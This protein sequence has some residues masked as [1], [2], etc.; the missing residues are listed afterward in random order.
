MTLKFMQNPN[1]LD[2]N[3]DDRRPGIG[4]RTS[5]RRRIEQDDVDETDRPI[6][7]DKNSYR[8]VLVPV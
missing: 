4:S 5:S 7:Q 8:H 1:E 6:I 3:L 2:K